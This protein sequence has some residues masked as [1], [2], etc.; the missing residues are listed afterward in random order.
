[1]RS[2][3]TDSLSKDIVVEGFSIT[4]GGKTLFDNADL[5]ISHGQVCNCCKL[6]RTSLEL[7]ATCLLQSCPLPVDAEPSSEQ[8]AM[9][10]CMH[11][12]IP[13]NSQC[14]CV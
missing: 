11:P 12:R 7:R 10:V 1:M 14:M 13:R 6:P 9:S 5:R 2:G 4:V 3:G 8:P